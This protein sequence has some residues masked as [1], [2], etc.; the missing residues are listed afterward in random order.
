MGEL[1]K[2]GLRIASGAN[3]PEISL[4]VVFKHLLYYV[5]GRSYFVI[6]QSTLAGI[7]KEV[8]WQKRIS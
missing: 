8:G 7:F 1:I 6:R 4:I 5:L 2:R 3:L